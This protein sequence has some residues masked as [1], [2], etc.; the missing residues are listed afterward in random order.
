MLFELFGFAVQR[1]FSAPC[2]LRTLG[3]GLVKQDHWAQ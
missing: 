3:Y 2:F 1:P